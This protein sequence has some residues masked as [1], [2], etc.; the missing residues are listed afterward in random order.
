MI[1]KGGSTFFFLDCKSTL[2]QYLHVALNLARA[3][4]QPHLPSTFV[5]PIFPDFFAQL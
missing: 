3:E 4:N 1:K 5:C 2:V